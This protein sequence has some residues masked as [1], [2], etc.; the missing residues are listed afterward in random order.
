MSFDKENNNNQG[1]NT[2]QLLEI[3]KGQT[4][5]GILVE[6]DGYV[7]RDLSPD[8]ENMVNRVLE[9][10]NN[11]QWNVPNPF[12]MDVI[13]QKHS[14][15]N[16]NG[17]IYPEHILK[18][19]VEK[20][21]ERIRDH[22]AIGEC[23]TPDAMVLCK[24]GWKSIAEVTD[25]DIVVTLNTLTGDIELQDVTKKIEYDFDGNLV[26]LEGNNISEKVTPN[27]G[28][29]IYNNLGR[30]VDFYT[31]E[32]ILGNKIE[33]QSTSFIP[34]QGKWI[35]KGDKFFLLKGLSNVTGKPIEEHPESLSDK[36]I[37]MDVFMKFIAVFLSIGKFN[38]TD[39][40]IKITVPKSG[41]YDF[42]DEL[43]VE[44][45][46]SYSVSSSKGGSRVYWIDDPRVIEY[47]KPLG[48][49]KTAYIPFELKQQSAE[50]LKLFYDVYTLCKYEMN[51]HLYTKNKRTINKATT[52]SKRLALDINEIQLK[53]G[54]SG[55][56]A[57]ESES[58]NRVDGSS[59]FSSKL[60]LSRGACI[61]KDS[62]DASLV[63]YN[64]KVMCIEVPNHTFY[65]MSNG[66]CH[67]SK[68]CNHPAESTI[69]LGRIAINIIECHW[70]KNTLVGKVEFN[71]TEGFRRYGICSSFGD[72]CANLIINGIKIGVSSR[73]VGEVTNRMGTSYVSNY[74]LVCWD[75][76]ADPS[77][78][79]AFLGKKEDLQQYVESNEKQGTSLNEKINKV[80]SILS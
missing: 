12:V 6:T 80:K 23:Y 52:P 57:H 65:V 30:F 66:K 21:Q 54:Y 48:D 14:I 60:S 67:W 51:S 8:N 46:F 3:K 50:N 37:P 41:L 27:H 55:E 16:A 22:R 18:P 62:L 79:G 5:Y 11:G 13:L 15:K 76:V 29:P 33:N 58:Q 34:K 39:K 69:D 4:G 1:K 26:K 43:M 42:L 78:P 20:Y 7:S 56:F 71:L 10:R 36:K 9:S 38:K 77:T 47:V 19:E 44:L 45:D 64:G 31:A 24:E 32:D 28:Y 73:G 59:L 68:N 70:E 53:M 25:T 72:T 74:E 35:E 40:N 75:V 61:G 2:Q 49:V 63:P 17:R